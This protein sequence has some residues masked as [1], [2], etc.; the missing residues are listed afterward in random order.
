LVDGDW[1][2]A[3]GFISEAR[4]FIFG[5][6]SRPYCIARID[7]LLFRYARLTTDNQQL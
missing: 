1:T 7:T 6:A 3:D 5:R 4:A 2:A